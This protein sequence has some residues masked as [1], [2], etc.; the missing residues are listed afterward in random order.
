[1]NSLLD[2]SKSGELLVV[3]HRGSSGTAPENTISAFRQALD[4]GAK[5]V[6]IDIQIT[7]D[8]KFVVYH[9]FVPP[10]YDKRISELDF[11]EIKDIDIGSAYGNIYAGEKI[12]LLQ[13]VLELVRDKALLMI[14]IKTWTGDKIQANMNQLIELI[15]EF[16]SLDKTVFGSFNYK[17]LRDLKQLN[18]NIKTAAIKI[19]GDDKSPREIRELTQ[20][21]VFIFSVEE[22]NQELMESAIQEGLFTGVYSV[23]TKASLKFALEH[24]VRAVATNYPNKIFKWLDEIKA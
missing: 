8:N 16:N 4:S 2:V 5:M 22:L 21:E 10:G 20:C 1:M 6:E 11:D 23:D 12:P 9:D 13:E 19:P 17:V 14:E 15:D 24:K 7:A 18:P 3:A